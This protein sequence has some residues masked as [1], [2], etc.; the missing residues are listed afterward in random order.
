MCMM[1]ESVVPGVYVRQITHLYILAEAGDPDRSASVEG[2]EG[3]LMSQSDKRETTLYVGTSLED[4][5][6]KSG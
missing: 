5:R 2:K 6:F 1:S 3:Y 4:I